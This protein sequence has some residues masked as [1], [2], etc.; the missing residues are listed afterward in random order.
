MCQA[1]DDVGFFVQP[2]R[3]LVQWPQVNQCLVNRAWT[4]SPPPYEEARRRRGRR[5]GRDEGEGDADSDLVDLVEGRRHHHRIRRME[6]VEQAEELLASL[7][8]E[9]QAADKGEQLEDHSASREGTAAPP[10]YDP[11]VE[12]AAGGDQAAEDNAE[13]AIGTT[14]VAAAAAAS[15]EKKRRR[16]KSRFDAGPVG[17]D[18][19]VAPGAAAPATTNEESKANEKDGGGAVESEEGGDDK[20]TGKRKRRSRWGDTGDKESGSA[21]KP[22]VDLA[23]MASM[24]AGQISG[25]A[26]FETSS[27]PQVQALQVRL[28]W[29]GRLGWMFLLLLLLWWWWWWWWWW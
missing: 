2:T 25:A 4:R 28:S 24:V 18:G 26:G 22:R 9:V 16:R 6:A 5:G 20:A 10:E 15:G 27:D 12:A 17:G 19:D 29:V 7:E 1:F 3:P 23:M 13:E 21:S 11:F 8:A 14:S